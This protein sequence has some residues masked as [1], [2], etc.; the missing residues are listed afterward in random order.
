[1]DEL[2]PVVLPKRFEA[3][4]QGRQ[5]VA[6]ARALPAQLVETGLV[7]RH[8]L[9]A[10]GNLALQRFELLLGRL[11]LLFCFLEALLLLLDLL[12]ELVEA[13]LR[14]LASG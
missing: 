7:G 6:E 12:L 2:V 9:F 8:Q 14:G 5:R 4:L 11:R 10:E 1:V 13:L 3:R